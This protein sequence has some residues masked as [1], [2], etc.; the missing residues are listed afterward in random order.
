[1][2]DLDLS[3]REALLADA[4][5]AWLEPAD[6]A[7]FARVMLDERAGDAL[8]GFADAAAAVPLALHS[9]DEV[10]VAASQLVAIT[11]KLQADA[12]A[13]FAGNPSPVVSRTPSPPFLVEPPNGD[14][15][16]RLLPWLL[17]AA[18]LL[19]WL[20]PVDRGSPMSA[21]SRAALLLAASD[22]Q[23]CSLQPGPSPLRGGLGGDI[24]WNA[25][26]QEGYLRLRGFVPLDANHR[27]QLW[28][29]D[30]ARTGPP[31]DG[32]LFALPA[33]AG[34]AVIRVDA[35]LPVRQVTA[36]VLTVEAVEGA[37]VSAQENVVAI[38]KL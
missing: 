5:M 8:A 17:V 36:F 35:R 30:A 21:Q 26:R 15:G 9:E 38:A 6:E 28:I 3:Q 18:S 10:S 20:W 29:V 2:S 32:G 13:W 33:G 16:W 11:A 25:R 12:L 4:T 34:D 22:T 31:V 7:E 23:Q 14:R 37:V 19:L 27:Y 1:M 24:V